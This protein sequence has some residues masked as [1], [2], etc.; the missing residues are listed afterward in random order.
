MTTEVQLVANAS[1]VSKVVCAQFGHSIAMF[2][3]GQF[4]HFICTKCGLSRDEIRSGHLANG[5]PKD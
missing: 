1:E 4:A 2:N 3:E 5:K